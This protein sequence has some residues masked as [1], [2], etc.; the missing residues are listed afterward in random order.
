MDGNGDKLR[1][2]IKQLSGLSRVLGE[3][4]GNVVDTIKNL[5][6]FV[7]VLLRQQRPDRLV[8]GPAGLGLLPAWSTAAGPI[9]TER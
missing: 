6:T 3:G 7:T 8:P 1:E 2:T 5:Q 9:S 4:S